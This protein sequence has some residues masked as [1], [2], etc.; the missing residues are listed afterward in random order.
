M[1]HK[2]KKEL[3]E[4]KIGDIWSYDDISILRVPHGWIYFC[5]TQ[6]TFVPNFDV[7]ERVYERLTE[8]SKSFHEMKLY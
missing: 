5:G 4:M 2:T 8:I 7:F 1:K 6:Q 3:L